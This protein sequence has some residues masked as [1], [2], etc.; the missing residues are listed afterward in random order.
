MLN[1]RRRFRFSLVYKKKKCTNCVDP[2]SFSEAQLK[3]W[4][5][6]ILGFRQCSLQNVSNDISLGRRRWKLQFKPVHRLQSSFS[7][8]RPSYLLCCILNKVP[9]PPHFTSF[10]SRAFSSHPSMAFIALIFP[11]CLQAPSSELT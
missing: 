5:L 7:N 1:W 11:R 4:Y 3:R 6:L 10:F 8:L 2:K 9:F